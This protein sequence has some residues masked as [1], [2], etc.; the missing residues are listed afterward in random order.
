MI[1]ELI[2]DSGLYMSMRAEIPECPTPENERKAG[3]EAPERDRNNN[4]G[5][6]VSPWADRPTDLNLPL[7]C[8]TKSKQK[9]SPCA[10]LNFIRTCSLRC[11]FAMK[12]QVKT[13][14]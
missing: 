10:T 9:R 2:C 1:H 6:P 11:N 4:V 13:T 14:T 3:C 12:R 7:T 8:R 5:L